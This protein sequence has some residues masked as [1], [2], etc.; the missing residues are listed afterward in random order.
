MGPTVLQDFTPSSFKLSI[1]AFMQT[2]LNPDKN[3]VKIQLLLSFLFN[4]DLSLSPLLTKTN[5][6]EKDNSRT[7]K[8]WKW[9][10]CGKK[11][12]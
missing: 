9:S 5:T 8:I 4:F 6:R 3:E 2:F 7:T 11:S 12:G 10:Y 1:W